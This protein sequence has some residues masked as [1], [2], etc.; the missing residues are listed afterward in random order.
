[1]LGVFTEAGTRRIAPGRRRDG[2]GGTAGL[3]CAKFSAENNICISIFHWGTLI[4]VFCPQGRAPG[5][6]RGPSGSRGPGARARPPMVTRGARGGC[7]PRAPGPRGQPW[8][9]ERPKSGLLRNPK[10]IVFTLFTLL[11]I[12]QPP[13]VSG[14]A[15]L[16][17]SRVVRL[18]LS[19][20]RWATFEGLTAP[21]TA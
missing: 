15:A 5:Q 14:V 18:R 4:R 17:N 20:A 2:A 7:L 16:L 6:G 1:M 19:S 10:N 11:Y 8:R 12:T 9:R 21:W 3:R 13:P